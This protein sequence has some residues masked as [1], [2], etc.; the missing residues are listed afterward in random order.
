MAERKF[1]LTMLKLIPLLFMIAIQCMPIC[2]A[3]CIFPWVAPATGSPC[4]QVGPSTQDYHAADLVM[5]L[6]NGHR[7][8]SLI[9]HY[10]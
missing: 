10:F 4:Y 6:C 2:N 3:D 9:V 1:I 8:L 5:V 7:H